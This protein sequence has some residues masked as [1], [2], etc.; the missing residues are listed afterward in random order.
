MSFINL[1]DAT[2]F[3]PELVNIFI[4]RLNFR[5]DLDF[6][7]FEDGKYFILYNLSNELLLSKDVRRAKSCTCT[8]EFARHLDQFLKILYFA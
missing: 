4:D 8:T 6:Y 7:I 5:L 3:T 2:Y 1:I